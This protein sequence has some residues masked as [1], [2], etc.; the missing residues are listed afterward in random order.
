M[1]VV[2]SLC[3]RDAND[4]EARVGDNFQKLPGKQLVNQVS[5]ELR[6]GWLCSQSHVGW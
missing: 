6:T 2:N 3:V 5:E 1:G 4:A